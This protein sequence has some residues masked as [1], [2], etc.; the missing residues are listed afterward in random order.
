MRDY[1]TGKFGY[2]VV[3]G[4]CVRVDCG[5]AGVEGYAMAL[6]KLFNNARDYPNTICK[7]KNN[8]GNDIFV[9]C[10][11][12][13]LE[14]VKNFCNVIYTKYEPMLPNATHAP[15]GIEIGKVTDVSECKLVMIDYDYELLDDGSDDVVC[16][17][18]IIR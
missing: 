12:K 16:G 14:I 13:K 6:L 10:P 2:E 4:Y 17:E 7:I 18:W 8:Y 11:K 15:K 9:Y 1:K 5:Q 3:D